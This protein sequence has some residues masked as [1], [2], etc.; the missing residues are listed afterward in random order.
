MAK[1]KVKITSKK[2]SGGKGKFDAMSMVA[3]IGGGAVGGIAIDSVDLYGG[4]MVSTSPYISPAVVT[5]V[6]AIAEM[7]APKISSVAKGI[8]G[9]TGCTIYRAAFPSGILGSGTSTPPPPATTTTETTTTTPPA[10][11]QNFATGTATGNTNNAVRGFGD[12]SYNTSD[13]NRV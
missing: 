11:S 5:G 4:S 3:A 13:S 9:A 1:K 2:K 8:Y 6:T 10:Q 7:F 12:Y